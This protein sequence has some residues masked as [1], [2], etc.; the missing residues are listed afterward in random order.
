MIKI[1]TKEKTKIF[2]IIPAFNEA[3]TIG[4]LLTELK[5]AG[6]KNLVVIDDDS[7]DNTGQIAQKLGATVLTHII[8]RGLGGALRTGFAYAIAKKANI[9]ITMDA[10]LQHRI[11]NIPN[12]VKPIL[13]G[14]ADVVIGKR[15]F[16][17]QKM[18][19]KRKIA[20]QV[21][22][23]FTQAFFGFRV[24][25]SQSGFRCFSGSALKKLK[26]YSNRMEISSEIIAEIH[27]NQLRFSEVPITTIY[28]KY[29]LSKGQSFKNGIKTLLRLIAVRLR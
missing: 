15:K 21:G 7:R 22:N 11:E 17:S 13:D 20:N 9:I 16:S 24:A 6:Y 23:I 18:P 8:N 26:L 28:T 3:K 1:I 25:D 10:D 14:K 12:L 5:K 4:K 27:R 19:V 2:I 29:S